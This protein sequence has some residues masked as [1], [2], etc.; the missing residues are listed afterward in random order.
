MLGKDLSQ[1]SADANEAKLGKARRGE[2]LRIVDLVLRRLAWLAVFTP[3]AYPFRRKA[4]IDPGIRRSN[5][6]AADINYVHRHCLYQFFPSTVFNLDL[7]LP[8]HLFTS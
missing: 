8:S 1:F 2:N 3:Y 4:L 5:D 6:L 7:S